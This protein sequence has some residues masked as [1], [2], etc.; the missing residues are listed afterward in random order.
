MHV[1]RCSIGQGL[2]CAVGLYELPQESPGCCCTGAIMGS[3]I[4]MLY[5]V[6]LWLRYGYV[7]AAATAAVS[8]RRESVLWPLS[9][10]GG[11][12]HVCSSYGSSSLLPAS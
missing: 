11:N 2:L 8:E 5:E 12:K 1:M 9:Q 4:V 10:P 3:I 6:I 7:V